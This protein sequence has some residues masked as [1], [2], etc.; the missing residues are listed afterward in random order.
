V[1][2]LEKLLKANTENDDTLSS[3]KLFIEICAIPDDGGFYVTIPA[4]GRWFIQTDGETIKESLE[5]LNELLVEVLTDEHKEAYY[6]DRGIT[7][8]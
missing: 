5:K 2:F 8:P 1:E 7:I 3:P 6:K 4:L